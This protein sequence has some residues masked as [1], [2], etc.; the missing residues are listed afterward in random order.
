M[1]RG[2]I[3][4]SVRARLGEFR[5]DPMSAQPQELHEIVTNAANF[6]AQQLKSDY[7][8]AP[9][10]VVANQPVYTAPTSVS[11]NQAIMDRKV[12]LSIWDAQGNR[13]TLSPSLPETL[14]SRFPA[15][16]DYPAAPVPLLYVPL[17]RQQFAIWPTPNWT[18]AFSAGNP[19][20]DPPV[21]PSGMVME[22]DILPGLTWEALTAECPIPTAYHDCVLF[23]SVLQRSMES[24]DPAK[25]AIG[26]RH[27]TLFNEQMDWHY[28]SRV[29]DNFATRLPAYSDEYEGWWNGD[30][31]ST[32]IINPV[33]LV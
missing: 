10:G 1:T 23:Y 31:G 5:G 28:V 18:A 2:H 33:I 12:A 8:T 14:D 16:R 24:P 3:E 15:W 32:A 29:R 19:N 9:I 27:K 6:V 30:L 13:H 22:G 25:A 7:G 26:A 20:A 11:L 17:G 4:G 21:P